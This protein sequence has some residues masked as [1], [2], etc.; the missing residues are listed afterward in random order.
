MQKFPSPELY[1]Y[2]VWT[3]GMQS[4]PLIFQLQIFCA[5]KGLPESRTL[6]VDQCILKC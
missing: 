4:T 6:P 5:A 3:W 1:R 2:L